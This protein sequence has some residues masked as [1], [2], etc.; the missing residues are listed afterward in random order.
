MTEPALDRRPAEQSFN[1][2]VLLQNVPPAVA[3]TLDRQSLIVIEEQ[4]AIIDW[5][6]EK[7][8]GQMP[9]KDLDKGPNAIAPPN[10][11][12]QEIRAI[13]H[14]LPPGM[15]KPAARKRLA[16]KGEELGNRL[17]EIVNYAES[18]SDKIR[19]DL[20]GVGAELYRLIDELQATSYEQAN[21][22]LI[23]SHLESNRRMVEAM[24]TV[25]TLKT[26][27]NIYAIEAAVAGDKLD[28]ARR[29]TPHRAAQQWSRLFGGEQLKHSPLIGFS[30]PFLARRYRK[31]LG[32]V[33]E[34]TAFYDRT[35]ELGEDINGHF[36][37]LAEFMDSLQLRHCGHLLETLKNLKQQFTE[38]PPDD[39][40]QE[41]LMAAEQYLAAKTEY[42]KR[43]TA[44]IAT[45]IL[46]APEVKEVVDDLLDTPLTTS[47]KEEASKE[48]KAKTEAATKQL[49]TA[50]DILLGGRRLKGN[51]NG[52]PIQKIVDGVLRV[53][54]DNHLTE[55]LLTPEQCG[56]IVSAMCGKLGSFVA[57]WE[58]ACKDPLDPE[59]SLG[60]E[61]RPELVQMLR[62]YNL[63]SHILGLVRMLGDPGLCKRLSGYFEQ[64]ELQRVRAQLATQLHR[65][66]KQE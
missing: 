3:E 10:L 42:T 32:Y 59:I 19:A 56:L 34:T 44:S 9:T 48:L 29:L 65:L 36:L 22:D 30:M 33:E 23:S 53:T 7:K 63:T 38:Q 57:T 41:Q 55:R 49:T 13:E 27:V 52:R 1:D 25:A 47:Q 15:S 31:G 8:G 21:F 51:G 45:E 66:Q 61:V 37:V 11:Q 64:D 62:E 28:Y 50:R 43:I 12:P 40:S 24:P 18:V 54:V 26:L 2:E 6:E 58:R 35:M 4:V 39:A 60:Y 46:E 16:A 17:P 5:V 20:E 14:L